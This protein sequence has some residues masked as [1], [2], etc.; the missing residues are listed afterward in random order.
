MLV[1]AESLLANC[2]RIGWDIVWPGIQNDSEFGRAV[3][4][5]FVH[6]YRHD[7]VAEFAKHLNERQMADMYLWL[8]TQYPYEQDPQHKGAHAVGARESIAH[9]RDGL[10][11]QLKVCGTGEA[12]LQIVR[13]ARELPQLTWLKWTMLDA[14][15]NMRMKTWRPPKPEHIIRLAQNNRRRYVENGR[16]L[17]D[18]LC[19]SLE[20]LEQKLHGEMPAVN[21][22]WDN[23]GDSRNA[24]YYPKDEI[25]FSDYIARHLR[26]NLE[27][28]R[29]IIINREVQIRRGQTDI[30][31]DA[32]NPGSDREGVDII[33]AIIEVKGCWNRELETAMKS[34]LVDRYL[35]DSQCP[36]GIY[37]VGWFR[38]EKWCNEDYRKRDTPGYSVNEASAHFSDQATEISQSSSIPDLNLKAFVLNTRL[39]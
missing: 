32:V 19:E 7:K 26:E 2:P 21:D 22:L 39:C 16:Q 23:R 25:H 29:G 28:Q 24:Q 33:K 37:L 8:T 14:E 34:Q 10:L 20:R 36:N 6:L 13:I 11:Q 18:V 9:F 30:H 31:I 27:Q 38:C 12:C 4:E 35:Q 17:L 5:K 3:F 15:R 1:V